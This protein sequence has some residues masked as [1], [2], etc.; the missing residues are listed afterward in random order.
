MNQYFDDYRKIFQMGLLGLALLMAGVFGGV[1]FSSS[2][3]QNSA[4]QT[5]D[6]YPV[7]LSMAGLHRHDRKNVPAEKAPN[8]NVNIEED[9][10]MPGHFNLKIN[11]ENFEFTPENASSQFVMG[12]GHAHV[13]VNDVKI[14][15]AYGKY[16]H[17]P[18]LDEGNHTVKVTLN[19]N[20]HQV[21]AVDGEV[22]QDK[23]DISYDGEKG[24]M[25]GMR[26]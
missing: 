8:V 19:T 26:R 21:Y 25:M 3:K 12:E 24:M 23:V 7:D 17:I 22:I 4:Q 9:P 1:Q 13:F 15:R 10:M 16:Y 14:S 2:L 18:R 6:T 11:T 20:D 5:L